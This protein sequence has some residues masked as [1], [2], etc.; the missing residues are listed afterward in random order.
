M[1]FKKE[2]LNHDFQLPCHDNELSKANNIIKKIKTEFNK[3]YRKKKLNDAEFLSLYEDTIRILDYIGK[4][5]TS[6]FDIN[7]EIEKL[8][9]MKFLHAPQLG[10]TLGQ[11]HYQYIHRPYNILKNRCYKI[12]EELDELY[13]M[14]HSKYSPNWNI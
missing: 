11:E 9:M 2:F 13:Q 8:Y 12:L 14:I 3:H 6:A 5:S 4:L 7:D 1:G 10:K